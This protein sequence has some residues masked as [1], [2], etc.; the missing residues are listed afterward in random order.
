MLWPF[1]EKLKSLASYSVG[2]FLLF[3]PSRIGRLCLPRTS[4][5][6]DRARPNSYRLS[7]LLS[8]KFEENRIVGFK[9]C[10]FMLFSKTLDF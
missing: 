7:F 10:H 6:A 8:G 2:P 1:C 4:Q 5:P 3:I 9:D